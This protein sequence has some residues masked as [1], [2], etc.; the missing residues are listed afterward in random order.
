[1]KT[2]RIICVALLFILLISVL[3]GC[4]N[5]VES[6]PVVYYESSE[7]LAEYI[8]E[9]ENLR[10]C[11]DGQTS[12]FTLEDKSSGEIWYSVPVD[13]SAD[14]MADA[15]MKKWLQSTMVLTYSISSGLSTIFDNYSNSIANGTFQITQQEEAIRV[16]NNAVLEKYG[17]TTGESA[18]LMVFQY[19][20]HLEEVKAFVDFLMEE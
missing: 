2:S 19:S 18:Y 13:G 6:D 5:T 3:C 14:T 9:N 11:M 7:N 12:Y 4:D 10:F 15:T 20:E 16:D 1:M 17:L 8:L